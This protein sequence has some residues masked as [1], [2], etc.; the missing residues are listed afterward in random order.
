MKLFKT[1]EEKAE[2]NIK[3]GTYLDSFACVNGSSNPEVV[4]I[5]LKKMEEMNFKL[6]AFS[7]VGYN[8]TER[9]Y[10]KKEAK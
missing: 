8:E 9:L 1:P 4:L 7:G 10:F 2:R 3:E 5:I 6:L